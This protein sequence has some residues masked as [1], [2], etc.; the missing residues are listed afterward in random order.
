MKGFKQTGALVQ[1]V[2]AVGREVVWFIL[3][4]A[5]IMFSFANAFYILLRYD[6]HDAIIK[7]NGD[8]FYWTD[9]LSIYLTLLSALMGGVSQVTNSPLDDG[10]DDDDDDG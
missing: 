2:Q 4:V 3:M 8:N 5:V 7:G 6:A 1:M 10:D 9:S